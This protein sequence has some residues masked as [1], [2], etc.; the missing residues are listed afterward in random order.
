MS[1]MSPL[2]CNMFD[3]LGF[4]TFQSDKQKQASGQMSIFRILTKI[5][6]YLLFYHF[7]SEGFIFFSLFNRLN[8]SYLPFFM[9][10]DIVLVL[11]D[12]PEGCFNHRL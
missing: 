8:A 3:V 11:F 5:T 10:Y 1:G 6:R 2:N 4:Q 7:I 12:K 9:H